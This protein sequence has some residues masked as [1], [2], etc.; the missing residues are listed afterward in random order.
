MSVDDDYW[1]GS[2]GIEEQSFFAS[3]VGSKQRF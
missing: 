1:S 2:K 3:S